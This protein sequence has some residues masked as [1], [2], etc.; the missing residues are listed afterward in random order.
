[1]IRSKL[2]NNLDFTGYKKL[3]KMINF[4]T[5]VENGFKV[6]TFNQSGSLKQRNF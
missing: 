6:P 4:G 3:V 1:L 5:S 2:L